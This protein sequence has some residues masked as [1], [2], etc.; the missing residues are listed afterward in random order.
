MVADSRRRHALAL[1]IGGTKIGLG[2]GDDLG[3]VHAAHQFP[4]DPTLAPEPLLGRAL[5]WLHAACNDHGLIPEA[6]GVAAP[7]PLDRASGRLLEVPN[8]LRW[9]GFALRDYLAQATAL[10]TAVQNDANAAVLAEVLWGAARGADTA[11]F[12]TMSTGMGAGLWIE[13][14]LIEGPC[15]L[16]GEIG[17]IRLTDEGPVGFGKRGSV[18]GYLS[19]P[20]LVQ[21]A[22]AEALAF[23]QRSAATTLPDPPAL[24]PEAVFAAAR[25]GDAAARAVVGTFTRMLGRLCAILVDL[26][27]PDVIVFGTIG[28]AHFDL[29]APGVGELLRVEAL[30]E[31][32]ARVA[33]RP[34]GLA[35]RGI[36]SALAVALAAL[37]R[38]AR[39]TGTAKHTDRRR[40]R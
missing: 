11:V 19:G 20:G 5:D 38:G 16:A 1:D 15:G 10:P 36:Q 6:V 2:I 39:A 21:L 32:A 22:A 9:Q 37:D 7:G 24:T 27:N 13:G 28:T 18:E 4:T 8:M 23:H 3:V 17:H 29:L 35:Q 34:S 26:L 30:P 12:L 33:L 40:P 31:S 14:R 25:A